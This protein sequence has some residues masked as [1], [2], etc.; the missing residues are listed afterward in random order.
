MFLCPSWCRGWLLCRKRAA[1]EGMAEPPELALRMSM[2]TFMWEKR[3]P[4]WV[5]SE[6]CYNI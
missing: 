3:G 6:K 2:G 1:K 4:G 5:G